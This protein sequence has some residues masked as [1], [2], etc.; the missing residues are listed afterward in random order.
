MRDPRC[1]SDSILQ[2]SA[3]G[4]WRPPPQR[5]QSALRFL[6]LRPCSP[7]TCKS[8]F[9]LLG[10]PSQLSALISQR[11][12]ADRILFALRQDKHCSCVTPKTFHRP[13]HFQH[14]SDISIIG[15]F[16]MQKCSE[17]TMSVEKTKQR[18]G[19]RGGGGGG[20]GEGQTRFR[21]HFHQDPIKTSLGSPPT[22]TPSV[23][24]A[25]LCRAQ[26][27]EQR[28]N[29]N[30]LNASWLMVQGQKRAKSS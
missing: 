1:C 8:Y 18:R 5:R 12:P 7:L 11:S 19:E 3:P 6:S 23:R 15:F 28:L 25:V 4:V 17:D 13:S 21:F 26:R 30:G 29:K 2:R 24:A 16:L 14:G 20:G 22:W 10:F 9:F 27:S